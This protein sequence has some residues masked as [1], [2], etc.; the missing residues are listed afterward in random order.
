MKNVKKIITPI[1]TF[2]LPLI[3]FFS[4]SKLYNNDL[5]VNET[6]N[7]S[8][9]IP[10]SNSLDNQ[11]ILHKDYDTNHMLLLNDGDSHA[12]VIYTKP[13]D[14]SFVGKDAE[15]RCRKNPEKIFKTSMS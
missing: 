7:N 6:T 12:F 2:L 5:K 8:K 13:Y 4:L 3:A 14:S 10:S 11:D 15:I 9:V 1:L